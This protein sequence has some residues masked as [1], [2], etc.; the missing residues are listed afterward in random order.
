MFLKEN[1]AYETFKRQF[2]K[3]MNEVLYI[4]PLNCRPPSP[5]FKQCPIFWKCHIY[6]DGFPPLMLIS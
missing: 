2:E 4:L 5:Q 1:I 6:F 3:N